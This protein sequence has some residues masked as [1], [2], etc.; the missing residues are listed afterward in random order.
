MMVKN[1]FIMS[2]LLLFTMGTT[3]AQEKKISG[4]VSDEAGMPL[5]GVNIVVKG[6]TNGTQTDFDGNYTIN[7]KVGDVLSYTYLG[8]KTTE[9]TIGNSSTI[10]VTMLEDA[11]VLDEVVVTGVAR[12]T[13]VKK[14]GF[15]LAKVNE[16]SLQKV[17]ATD[18]ANALRGKI[19]GVRVV[20]ASGDPSNGASIRLR[21]STSI[22]GS[23]SPLIIVDGI[24]T[25]GSIKDIPVED[26]ESMEVIKGAAA[27]SL[28]GSLA[29]NGV[30]QIITKKGRGRMNVSLKSE[31]GFSEIANSY[32]TTDV[33]GYLNDPNGVVFGD[34]DNDPSTPDTSNFGFDLSSG[35]RVLDPDG[36]FDNPYLST[37][38][39]NVENIFTNQPFITNTLSLNGSTKETR[40]Y[41]SAQYNELGGVI[42]P[43]DPFVRKTFRGNF[44]V[45]PTDKLDIK[46]NGS[47]TDSKGVNITQQGQ[48]ANIFYSALLAEPFIDLREKDANGDYSNSPSGY[49]VQGSN[50]QNPLYVEEQ[51]TNIFKRQRTLLGADLNYK[52][53]DKFSI[54]ATQSF[55]Q[56]ATEFY[57]FYPKGFITPT[58]SSALNNG[59]LL[60]EERVRNTLVSSIQANYNEQFGDLNFGASAKY[61]FENRNFRRL[62]AGGF[63]FIAE[64]V[65]D[66]SNIPLENRN[67][68]SYFQKEI[69]KNYFLNLDF[70]YQDKLIL[71]LLGRRDES[72]YFGADERVRYY[73]RAALAYRLTQDFDI[74]G[75]QELKLRAAYGTSGQRPPVFNAQ[76]ETFT[77]GTTSIVPGTLGNKDLKASVSAELEVGLNLDFLDRFSLELNYSDTKTTDAH[78]QVPLSG[79]AGFANQWQN[80]GEI[81]SKYF[82]VSLSGNLMKKE[83]FD[84]NFNLNFD[85]GNQK[86]TS[87]N[88][89]PAFTRGGLGAVDIFRVEEGL[90]YGT[91][92][93]NVLAT[94]L[95]DLVVDGSGIVLNGGLGGTISEYSINDQGHVV[96][97]ADIGTA[98]ENPAL[99]FDETTNTNK[100][101]SI[102]NT[103]PDFNV[104]FSTSFKYKNLGLYIL[105][106]WQQG[107]DIYNYTKQLLYFNERHEDLKKLASAGK[108]YN[109]AQNVYNKSN[110]IDYFVEDGTFVKIREISLDYTLNGDQIGNI[111]DSIRFAAIGRNLFTFTNYTGFDPEV[112]INTNPTNFRLDEFAYPN[113]RSYSF[114]VELKF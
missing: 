93:G 91:M 49:L 92:Y 18:A 17:P 52:F 8:L 53:N 6:T 99:L 66:I 29:G 104:G 34:W 77:V 60:R 72:S 20:A 42:E 1:Y 25:S 85:K 14:L 11:A 110:P 56:T 94:S 80:I 57:R 21:G 2:L 96:K 35:N 62:R 82:E 76:Y 38:H 103:N 24:I 4:T 71:N 13:S 36:L 61:L 89:V 58:P 109:Y 9:K 22:S 102:G 23:Q 28:Y 19:A 15:S 5:P 44:A 37:T 73:G 26:I 47:L 108:H 63:G 30:I 64:G 40:Y 54:S 31:Y 68:F 88:G 69:A 74:K 87:L 90:P 50:F 100:V 95:D 79:V 98:N 105:T 45:S 67:Q 33:H 86:I 41:L 46:F 81:Q 39:D 83:D 16:E 106:D 3:M 113:F 7:A 101:K 84:W 78:I 12:G 10:D 55:D 111:F 32:P 43:V 107:G 59:N 70:D 48:G 112:A 97:T 75:I 114:S 27:A 51:K 65:T